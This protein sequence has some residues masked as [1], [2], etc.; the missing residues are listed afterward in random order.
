MLLGVNTKFMHGAFCGPH[1]DPFCVRP[2]GGW[3]AERCLSQTLG[4]EGPGASDVSGRHQKV[5]SASL[6]SG[7]GNS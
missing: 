3:T 1:D 2:L 7:Q 5:P 4:H 6:L